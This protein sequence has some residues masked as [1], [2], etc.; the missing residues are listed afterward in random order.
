MNKHV[1]AISRLGQFL[2]YVVVYLFKFLYRHFKTIKV[3][4]NKIYWIHNTQL[5]L[6]IHKANQWSLNDL[7]FPEVA[8]EDFHIIISDPNSQPNGNRY[9]R[10]GCQLRSP[11]IIIIIIIVRYTRIPLTSC[12]SIVRCSSSAI[13]AVES[14][15]HV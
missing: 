2:G 15:N 9:P 7:K 3:I 6:I 12:S 14:I 11:G 13:V 8:K 10:K 5:I 4:S 1:R